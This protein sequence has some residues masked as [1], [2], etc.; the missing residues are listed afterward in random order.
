MKTKF[1]ASG[2]I[3]FAIASSGVVAQS[4]IKEVLDGGGKALT[5]AELM[6]LLPG[7][8]FSGPT[9]SGTQLQRSMKADGT[10]SGNVGTTYG[11]NAPQT[12][13]WKVEDNGQ[14]CISGTTQFRESSRP[15]KSCGLVY[16][17]GN[18]YFVAGQGAGP[19]ARVLE[20]SITK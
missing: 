13:E 17:L 11:K 15:D 5:K 1:M 12:G 9:P 18:K 2:A 20:R 7:T 19:D 10:Y 3:L 4:T 8:N 16:K 6:A 14:L